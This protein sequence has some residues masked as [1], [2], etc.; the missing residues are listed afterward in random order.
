MTRYDTGMGQLEDNSNVFFIIF[1]W[2]SCIT[3]MDLGPSIH[4][5]VKLEKSV[6]LNQLT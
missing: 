1:P 4:H 3:T 5:I 2:Y 6:V